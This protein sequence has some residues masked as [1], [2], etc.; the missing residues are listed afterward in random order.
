MTFFS[1]FGEHFCCN[2]QKFI[3]MTKTALFAENLIRKIPGMYASDDDR[4]GP[5][6]LREWRINLPR[7]SVGD[8]TSKLA[9]CQAA[10]RKITTVF[11]SV[12]KKIVLGPLG[13]EYRRNPSE[14]FATTSVK[15]YIYTFPYA[16][17]IGFDFFFPFVSLSLSLSLSLYPIT[18]YKAVA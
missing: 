5:D 18:F 14:S 3:F 8:F 11:Q 6:L 1:I 15:L 4:C 7:S 9:P 17:S 12:L 10:R 16:E 13:R 2:F